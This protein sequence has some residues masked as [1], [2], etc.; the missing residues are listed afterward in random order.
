MEGKIIPCIILFSFYILHITFWRYKFNNIKNEQNIKERKEIILKEFE[1]EK[2]IFVKDIKSKDI[3]IIS[4]I[5]G[6][7]LKNEIF[8]KGNKNIKLS[9]LINKNFYQILNH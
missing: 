8:I 2:D 9:K 1:D 5:F 4:K 6:W 3:F 7:K